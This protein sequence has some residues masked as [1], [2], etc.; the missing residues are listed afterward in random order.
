MTVAAVNTLL[1]A[2]AILAALSTI[3][4]SA[5]IVSGRRVSLTAA[6]GAVALGF[7]IATV[8]T[9]GSLYYSLSAG[10]PPC[11]L[12]W[13]QRIAIY[14]QTIILGVALVADDMKV[15]RTAIPLATIGA[16]LS[17]WHVVL[18]K[19]PRLSG[20]CD[21]SNPCAIKWVEEFGFLTIPTMAL[22]A[23]LSIA[24]LAGLAARYKN[25][26]AKEQD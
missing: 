21:V 24:V 22:I 26:E 10:F 11:D 16:A 14:P 23:S 15:G 8:A 4:A 19:F 5:I 17:T 6:R 7:S 13:Y 2:L 12:C 20:P 1:G 25:E 3:V 18:E 9:I